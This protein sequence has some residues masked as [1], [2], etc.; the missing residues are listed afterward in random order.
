MIR[1][2]IADDFKLLREDMTE[3]INAQPDMIVVAIAQDGKE[4]VKCAEENDYDII[5]MD[6][7]MESTYSGIIATEIIK[8]RNKDA[9][10]IFLTAHETDQ[11]ILSA[12]GTGAIDYIVK[13]SPEEQIIHHIRSAYNGNPIMAGK[14]QKI[15]MKEYKRL[16]MSEK[17][18]LFFINNISEL[19]P[20]EK[21]II[22]LLL[23]KMKVR[24]I[25]EERGVEVVTIK[26]Q[27]TKLLQKLGAKRTK[28]IVKQ[29][30]DLNLT[31]LF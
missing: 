10:I 5:L 20:T 9:K 12:M 8:N 25:A 24:E 30:I 21:E 13:G 23:K 3:I 1:I 6:I 11:M 27:I 17:S 2:I 14:V 15:I 29:I 22:G 26:T 7:E 31:H 19:T 28:E 4:I 16:Q 18:L